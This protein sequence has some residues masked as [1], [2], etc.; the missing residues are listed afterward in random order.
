MDKN[1]LYVYNINYKIKIKWL[2]YELE[3]IVSRYVRHYTIHFNKNMPGQS[4]ITFRT[5]KDLVECKKVL[6]GFYLLGRKL[7]SSEA[8]IRKLEKGT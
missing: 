1:V 5:R 3:R 7:I 2:K 4:F 8:I 6:D